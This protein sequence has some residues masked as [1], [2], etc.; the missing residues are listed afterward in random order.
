M[1]SGGGNRA[2][3]GGQNA[4]SG[5]AGP[6]APWI[7]GH[8]CLDLK[9]ELGHTPDLSPGALA[10]V[11]PLGTSVGGAVGNVG[12]AL[13]RLGSR[14][15]LLARSGHDPLAG[16]LRTVL[17][18]DAHGATLHLV[19]ADS[20]TS[21]TVVLKRPD[22]DRTFLHHAGCNHDFAPEDL[23]SAVPAG[24]PLLHLGYPP[25]MRGLYRD[26]GRGLAE[27]LRSL[28]AAGT[29]VSLDMALPDP[30][31]P[32]GRV[33]WRAFLQRVLPHVDLFVPSWGE[34]WTMLWPGAPVPAPS[35][36]GV[37]DVADELLGFGPALVGLKL[38]T[39]G[40]YLRSAG[41]ERTA[42]GTLPSL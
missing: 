41:S 36:P 28:R 11:G 1:S 2:G 3:L 9:P 27:A 23:T 40:L 26:E 32:S 37:R 20:S 7:A 22:A 35:R 24:A 33:D 10:E 29:A 17:G 19:E 38:G 31:G 25:L 8:L 39:D 21:Y 15:H 34:I 16:L 14:P 42:T 4:A 5:N 18:R 30:D 6:D 12:L 13:A